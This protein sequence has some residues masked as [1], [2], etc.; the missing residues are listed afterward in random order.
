[1]NPKAQLIDW[2]DI[3]EVSVVG[4]F[5]IVAV[6][7]DGTVLHIEN[8]NNIRSY[9]LV[10]KLT[11]N[12]NKKSVRIYGPYE[13]VPHCEYGCAGKWLDL[14]KFGFHDFYFLNGFSMDKE[15]YHKALIEQE[16]VDKDSSNALTAL[17]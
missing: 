15:D 17:I 11:G 8:N 5:P 9:K 6:F 10:D 7:D 14:M 3:K 12:W 1:M 16:L 4:Q 13:C 2:F